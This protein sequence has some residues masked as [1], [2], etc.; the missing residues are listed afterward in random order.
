[1]LTHN[2]QMVR[3]NIEKIE[4]ELDAK[5]LCDTQH[6]ENPYLTV[7]IFYCKE[8]HPDGSRYAGMFFRDGGLYIIDGAFVEDNP[9]T[10]ICAE[11]GDIIYSASQ[12]DFVTSE[13][14][15]VSADGGRSYN[16]FLFDKVCV[17]Y[18]YAVQD[19]KFIKQ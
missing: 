6:P 5:Y 19:G 14:G 8:K 3:K 15:T 10:G 2:P 18:T 12:H 7:S 9:I 16:R 11:N 13:D 4:S 17:T 1:M